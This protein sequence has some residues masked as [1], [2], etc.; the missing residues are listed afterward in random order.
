MHGAVSW[1]VVGPCGKWIVDGRRG[2]LPTLVCLFELG[3]F[4]GVAGALVPLHMS[5]V[6]N[7][8]PPHAKLCTPPPIVRRLTMTSPR[9]LATRRR[10]DGPGRARGATHEGLGVPVHRSGCEFC[11]DRRRPGPTR[12]G[13]GRRSVAR[14]HRAGSPTRRGGLLRIAS[15]GSKICFSHQKPNFKQLAFSP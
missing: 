1:T 6:S 9:G 12:V 11:E 2:R 10:P 7:A 14:H 4:G 5:A 8:G 3:G 15:V 13:P